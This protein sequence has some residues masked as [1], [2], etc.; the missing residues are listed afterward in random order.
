M[1][2]TQAMSS[3]RCY[4]MSQGEGCRCRC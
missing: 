4:K 2:R 1:C 3:E